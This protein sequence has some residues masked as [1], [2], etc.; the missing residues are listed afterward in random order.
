MDRRSFFKRFGFLAAMF[1]LGGKTV[2]QEAK[3]ETAQPVDK[4]RPPKDDEVKLTFVGT[5]HGRV[6]TTRAHSCTLLQKREKN[7]DV[8]DVISKLKENGKTIILITHHMD[9]ASKADR[10]IVLDN[11]K[12]AL[13]E[14]PTNVFSK[15]EEIKNAGIDIPQ[16]KLVLNLVKKAG[17]DIDNNNLDEK[18][19]SL[20]IKRYLERR[21]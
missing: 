20:E 14:T 12:I 1:G 15:E 11:G 4:K 21:M 17:F 13:E 19:A 2:A 9:E 8:M 5:S 7:Y 3:P 6:T 10:M 18:S 16:A